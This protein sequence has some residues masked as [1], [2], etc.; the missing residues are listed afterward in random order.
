M[1]GTIHRLRWFPISLISSSWHQI[2]KPRILFSPIF[3]TNFSQFQ[4]LKR[5]QTFYLSKT[6]FFFFI[7]DQWKVWFLFQQL[8]LRK[9]RGKYW[10]KQDSWF[11][12]LMSRTR[13]R[14]SKWANKNR[15]YIYSKCNC[16]PSLLHLRLRSLKMSWKSNMFFNHLIFKF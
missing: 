13:Y 5:K 6:D 7:L 2:T 3:S 15:T 14:I 11:G 9:I 8:K 4:Q 16:S 1:R 12:G 10:G